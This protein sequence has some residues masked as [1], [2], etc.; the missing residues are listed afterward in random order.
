MAEEAG[1]PTD[2]IICRRYGAHKAIFVRTDVTVGTEVEA[3]IQL[4]TKRGGRLDV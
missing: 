1:K 3:L 4:A 2:E